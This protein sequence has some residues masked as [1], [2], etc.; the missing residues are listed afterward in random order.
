MVRV[1]VTAR[2]LSHARDTAPPTFTRL[3]ARDAPPRSSYQITE[4]RRLRRGSASIIVLS[5]LSVYSAEPTGS[6]IRWGYVIFQPICE[7]DVVTR[8]SAYL[9]SCVIDLAFL[10]AAGQVRVRPLPSQTC[11]SPLFFCFCAAP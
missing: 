7:G 6:L 3:S 1:Q 9:I 11:T 2:Q 8:R 10:E 5:R 4:R